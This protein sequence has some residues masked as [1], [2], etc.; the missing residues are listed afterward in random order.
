MS[1]ARSK[2]SLSTFLLED[3]RNSKSTK[4]QMHSPSLIAMVAIPILLFFSDTSCVVL[5]RSGCYGNCLADP[6]DMIQI[7]LVSS[8][9]VCV[10]L[11]KK[12]RCCLLEYNAGGL[13]F[14]NEI[15]YVQL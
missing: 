2:L 8:V 3:T 15:L 12:Y 14:V 11:C 1:L 9:F 13:Q 5:K 10:V 4:M 7:T 6:S